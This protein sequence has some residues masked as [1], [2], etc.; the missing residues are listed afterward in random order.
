MWLYAQR[1]T[2]NMP[3]WAQWVQT[4]DKKTVSSFCRKIEHPKFIYKHTLFMH[5]Y[6]I[7][8]CIYVYICAH[9]TICVKYVYIYIKCDFCF[10][11]VF[12]NFTC[13]YKTRGHCSMRTHDALSMFTT[14]PC[15]CWTLSRDC[16][17][18]ETTAISD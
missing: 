1:Q 15:F 16:A 3:N 14:N 18:P 6:K 8:V 11:A 7:C 12:T 13:V 17:F 5:I 2:S 9:C 10:Y 4:I